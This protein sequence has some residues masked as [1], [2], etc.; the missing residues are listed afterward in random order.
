MITGL[1]KV[2]DIEVKLIDT[3]MIDR[4]IS[5]LNTVFR[6]NLPKSFGVK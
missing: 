1:A 5:H 2:V 6:H 4:R 3:G